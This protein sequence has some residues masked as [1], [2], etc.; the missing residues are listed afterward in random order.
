MVVVRV[1]SAIMC[2]SIAGGGATRQ[3]APIFSIM[4][5]DFGVPSPFLIVL[6]VLLIA[7]LLARR[8]PVLRSIVSLLFWVGAIGS[9]VF[10]TMERERFD[11]WLT[12]IA[13][14][15]SLESQQVAGEETRVRM[16]N[17]GHF[18]VRARMGG[19]ERRLLVDSGATVT[20]LSPATADA[21]GIDVRSS[22]SPC[23]SRPRTGRLGAHR[24]GG[25]TALR[26]RRRVRSRGGGVA[27]LR[28]HRRAGH[29][30]PVAPEI[31]AGGGAHP[32]SDTASS[33]PTQTSR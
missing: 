7:S 25:G 22:P 29:E 15:L 19:V 8:V 27:R 13:S 12:K 3:T 16:S 20:A 17:D 5:P 2:H 11:P 9:L 28:R 32:H 33:R 1:A 14:S 23:C 21:A 18:Y 4:S 31:V 24:R 6:G 26:Q 10:L 30:L